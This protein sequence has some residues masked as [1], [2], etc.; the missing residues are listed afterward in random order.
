METSQVVV[1]TVTKQS[2]NKA[3][4]MP[5]F[6]SDANRVESKGVGLKRAILN[7]Q[8]NFNVNA[9]NAGKLIIF[10]L[11]KKNSI[12]TKCFTTRQ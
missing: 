11:R 3:D 8:N 12:S 7:R 4:V 2:K 10:N 9:M 6:K 1:E 5:K